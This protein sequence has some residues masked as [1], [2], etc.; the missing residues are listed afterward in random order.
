[1]KLCFLTHI[2]KS[3]SI[4]FLWLWAR[5]TVALTRQQSACHC[6]R[7]FLLFE[8]WRNKTT[9]LACSEIFNKHNGKCYRLRA[10]YDRGVKGALRGRR[11]FERWYLASAEAP[12]LPSPPSC[13]MKTRADTVVLTRLRKYVT[14]QALVLWLDGIV[15]QPPESRWLMLP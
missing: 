5:N 2:E 3:N 12:L 15:H 14:S 1:M 9:R 13:K 4:S 8:K 7:L 11:R 10:W 6:R